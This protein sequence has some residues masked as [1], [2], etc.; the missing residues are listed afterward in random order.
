MWLK[1][2]FVYLTLIFV[3][4]AAGGLSGCGEDYSNEIASLQAEV[5][6][7]E[8]D[9]QR[10]GSDEL[11]LWSNDGIVEAET[12]QLVDSDGRMRALLD[13]IDGEVAFI[14][15]NLD[16]EPVGFIVVDSEGIV[17]LHFS[18]PEGDNPAQSSLD[19]NSLV[20]L[21]ED[22]SMAGFF[23]FD[24]IPGLLM[25]N[26]DGAGIYAGVEVI[27]GKTAIVFYDEEDNIILSSAWLDEPEP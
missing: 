21:G 7:L 8:A 27:D 14:L 18:S 12:I 13:T 19:P 2:G 25:S 1:S 16:D 5:N 9:I 15:M 26:P 23:I 11:A 22:E 3:T 10:L 4:V 17:G 20:F 24:D 6:S